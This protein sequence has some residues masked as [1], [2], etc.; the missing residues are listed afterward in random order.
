MYAD[1]L[2]IK[3]GASVVQTC[4]IDTVFVPGDITVEGKVIA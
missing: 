3:G 2:K 4:G 1:P